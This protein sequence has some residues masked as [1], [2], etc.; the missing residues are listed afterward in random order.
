MSDKSKYSLLITLDGSLTGG[1]ATLQ[2]GMTRFSDA[3]L[4]KFVSYWSGEWFNEELR[5]VQ[6][7]RGDPAGQARLE[8]LTLLHSVRT[9]KDILRETAGSVAVMGDALGVLHDACKFRAKDAVCNSIMAELALILAPMGYDLGAVHLWTQRNSTCDDL[10]RVAEGKAIP[11]ALKDTKRCQKK[12][13]NF[14][15]HL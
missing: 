12:P 15:V 14:R 3:H 10:S 11:P 1:G 7:E 4:Q 2:A 13:L 8:A 6:V 5:Q 9:W